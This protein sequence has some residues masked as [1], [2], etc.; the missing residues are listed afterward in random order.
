MKIEVPKTLWYEDEHGNF[1]G[2]AAQ[3]YSQP[4]EGVRYQVAQ[5]PC[6]LTTRW[7]E[8]KEDGSSETVAGCTTGWSEDL[9]LAMATKPRDIWRI[10]E[11]YRLSEAILIAA[12]ACERCMNALAHRYGLPWGYHEES[13]EYLQSRTRCGFCDH[14]PLEALPDR[15]EVTIDWAE[16]SGVMGTQ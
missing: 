11:P 6:D 14:Q 1:L 7:V 2:E 16:V 10:S 15:G 8:L 3:P 12:S 13:E 9:V 4:P 5:F